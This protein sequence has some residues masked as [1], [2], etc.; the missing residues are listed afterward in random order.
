MLRY[1]KVEERTE[2]RSPHGVVR[3]SILPCLFNDGPPY[4]SALLLPTHSHLKV[5]LALKVLRR[6]TVSNLTP[7]HFAPKYNTMPPS[8]AK[9]F[10]IT[11]QVTLTSAL[12]LVEKSKCTDLKL[13][14]DSQLCARKMLELKPSSL[15]RDDCRHTAS[16]R[17]SP[18][19]IRFIDLLYRD[20]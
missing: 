12:L 20:T 16:I 7:P 9:H 15:A 6:T 11:Q 5:I 13:E 8:Y 1:A 18:S 2:Q 3:P 17:L 4:T 19:S 10:Y 14:S